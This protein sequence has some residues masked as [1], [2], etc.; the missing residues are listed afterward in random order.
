MT[1]KKVKN[2]KET[3]KPKRQP[4]ALWLWLDMHL[5]LKGHDELIARLVS[6]IEV[7][8]KNRLNQAGPRYAHALR[9]IIA[10]CIEGLATGWARLISR[11]SEG[12]A[13]S[14]KNDGTP[15]YWTR[16][17]MSVAM[18]YLNKTGDLVLWM[19]KRSKR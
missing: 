4:V 11:R 15:T 10:N 6:G 1:M 5:L 16:T 14:R 9:C 19:G 13:K 18:D 12:Y 8:V 17:Y 3:R 7:Y 2:K